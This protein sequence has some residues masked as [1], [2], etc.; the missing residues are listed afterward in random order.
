MSE[1]ILHEDD[2]V[3]EFTLGHI[4][5][6]NADGLLL[7]M[8]DYRIRGEVWQVHKGDADPLPSRPHAHCVDGRGPYKGGKLHLGT[9]AV[10]AIVSRI[11]VIWRFSIAANGRSPRRCRYRI[12][13]PQKCTSAA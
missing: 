8:K 3:V 10:S 1:T 2:D 13:T 9:R 7:I 4:D 5:F 12:N 6:E 11:S